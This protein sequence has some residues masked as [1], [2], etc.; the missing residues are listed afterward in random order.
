[1]RGKWRVWWG[2]NVDGKREEGA[3]GGCGG[4]GKITLNESLKNGIVWSGVCSS[5][6]EE[7]QVA[8]SCDHGN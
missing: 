2:E 5:G 7:E 8:G 4:D 6:S 1:V 3:L